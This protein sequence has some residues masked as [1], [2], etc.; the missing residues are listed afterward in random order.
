[1][2]INYNL[3]PEESIEAYNIRIASERGDTPEELASTQQNI[4]QKTVDVAKAALLPITT[5]KMITSADLSAAPLPPA[6]EPV[7]PSIIETYQQSV[8]KTVDT[9]R[10]TLEA[11]YQKQLEDTRKRMEDAQKQID[12]F[13]K[14]QEGVLTGE[15]QTLLQP[16]REK[17]ESAERERLY[18]TENFEANQILTR[19]LDTLLTEGNA[20]IASERARP[21]ATSIVAARTN[22]AIQDV[23]ARAGV[24][25]AVMNARSGQIGEAYR[26]IDRSIEAITADRQDRLSYLNT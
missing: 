14:K 11:T 17:L 16:F 15:A 26:M 3:K 9:A 18:I 10:T 22:K 20:L 5:P 4:S 2:A 19:E 7:A 1:M 13:T 12:E 25:Q 21:I 23:Q 6:P 24:I 8:A